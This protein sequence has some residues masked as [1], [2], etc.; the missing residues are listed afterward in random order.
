MDTLTRFRFFIVCLLLSVFHYN[1]YAQEDDSVI[2]LPEIE[3]SEEKESVNHVG[4]EQMQRENSVDVWEAVRNIPGVIRSGGGGEDDEGGF[5]VRGFDSSRMP[6]FVDD[7]PFESPYQGNADYSRILTGDLES[8]DIQKGFAS[9]LLGPNT[10]GGAVLL[11]TAKP[12]KKFELNYRSSF[13]FDSAYKYSGSYN[14]LGIGSR[15]E[16]FY[17][18]SVFQ[19]RP[20]DHWRLSEN[21]RPQPANPQKE[22]ERLNSAST[23]I[24]LTML[25]GWTP[26]ENSSLNL[27]YTLINADKGLSPPEVNLVN[28]VSYDWNLWRRHT[29]K[30]DGEYLG[31]I[32]NS[33][34]YTKGFFYF[35]KFDT[36]VTQ[37]ALYVLDI[38]NNDYILGGHIEEEFRINDWNLLSAA[39]NVKNESHT[40]EDDGL[41]VTHIIEDT[42]SLGAEYKM[43]PFKFWGRRPLTFKVGAGTD[44]LAPMEFETTKDLS[45]TAPRYM[46]SYQAGLFFD[47]TKSHTVRLTFAKKNHIPSM[48]QR[49]ENIYEDT[50]DDSIP[51]PNLKNEAVFHYEAG[52]QGTI[53]H[54]FN[55]TFNSSLNIDFAVYYADLFD[56]IALVDITTS[57]GGKTKMRMN[58]D[59]TAYYGIESG[60]TL[61]L[62]R[63]FTSGAAL[64]F[65]RYKII[66][67]TTGYKIEGNFPRTTASAYIIIN[68]F[69]S[70]QFKALKTLAFT[71]AL[72]YEG[73]HYSHFTRLGTGEVIPRYLLFSLKI[74]SDLNEHFSVSAGIENLSD[75]NYYLDSAYLPM[76]GRTFNFTFNAKY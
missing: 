50:W 74:N 24:K 54:K 36:K 31:S 35:D 4:Q 47:I 26:D 10:M 29:V 13:D 58:I 66:S 3:I 33:E 1:L 42:F 2:E 68:P 40:R 76:P 49:Y 25:G 53:A 52:W 62:C 14:M 11:R 63:Y 44:I 61:Y 38:Y 75:A 56:M 28:P 67:N 9:M 39:F 70:F 45:Q 27:S 46:F 20:I 55:D 51:N 71:A 30:L 12:E 57:T 23:D 5:K 32:K 34:I 59:K 72:E 65:N 60:L 22:G 69:A 73:P 43:L 21:F 64:A 48:Y 16:K 6:L 19:A 8:I 15:Q 7:V 41:M 18:K 17:A 37:S